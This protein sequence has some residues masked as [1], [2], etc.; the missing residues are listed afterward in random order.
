MTGQAEVEVPVSR[1][2]RFSWVGTSFQKVRCGD[3]VPCQRNSVCLE[4][5]FIKQATVEN[6]VVIN[7]NGIYQGLVS[8]IKEVVESEVGT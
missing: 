2:A 8:F 3:S 1:S 7:M 6:P 5:D 4:T